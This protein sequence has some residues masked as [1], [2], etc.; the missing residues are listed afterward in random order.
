VPHI[1]SVDDEETFE[2]FTREGYVGVRF[3]AKYYDEYQGQQ[4]SARK[5]ASFLGT[6]YDIFADLKRVKPGDEI[7]LHVKGQQRIFGVFVATTRFLEDPSVPA[8]VQSINLTM[9]LLSSGNLPLMPANMFPWQVGICSKLDQCFSDG[10]ESNQVFRIKELTRQV[11][12]VPER[13]KY[14]DKEKTVRPILPDEAGPLTALLDYANRAARRSLVVNSKDLI[15]FRPISLPMALINGQIRDEKL[16]EAWLMENAITPEDEAAH[17]NLLEVL[18]EFTFVANTIRSFYIK[19]MDVFGFKQ[20]SDQDRTFKIVETKKG[21]VESKHIDQLARYVKWVT[22][23]LAENDFQK[24]RG[25]IIGREFAQ[26]A[27]S[28]LQRRIAE[29]I[30]LVSIRYAYRNGRFQLVPVSGT[31]SSLSTTQQCAQVI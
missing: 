7:F 27:L 26:D 14:E 16:L 18:G 17:R 6:M 22:E 10:F 25:Y 13:W 2:R 29:G 28:L 8:A 9:D 4:V 24:V 19:F 20:D 5:L 23:F 12:T 31:S 15:H 21:E 11:W 3:P 30:D 1:I